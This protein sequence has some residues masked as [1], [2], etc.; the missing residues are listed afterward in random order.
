MTRTFV[1][2]CPSTGVH[3]RPATAAEVAAY[4]AANPPRPFDRPVRVGRV[5]IDE[6]TGPGLSH[7]P[8]R[9]R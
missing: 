5:L 4:D 1:A 7:I 3:L 6:D 9:F 2:V 8:N